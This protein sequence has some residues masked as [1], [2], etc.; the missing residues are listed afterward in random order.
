M[1]FAFL[2]CLGPR[3]GQGGLRDIPSLFVF[4]MSTLK[5]KVVFIPDLRSIESSLL[6]LIN[7]PNKL[8]QKVHEIEHE[9]VEKFTSQFSIPQCS[10]CT[11]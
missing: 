10:L 7:I 8:A 9:I 2:F 5:N 3:A 6:N 1:F 4:K 11:S